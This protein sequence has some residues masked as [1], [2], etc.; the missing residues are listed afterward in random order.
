MGYRYIRGAVLGADPDRPVV[1]ERMRL[2]GDPGSRAPHMWLCGPGDPEPKSTV[3]LY[4]RSF[5][6]LCSEGTPWRAAGRSVAEQL[7][8]PL[9][10]YAIGTGP[11]A[12]L[13]P[14]NGGDWTEVHGTTPQG[15]ILVR[16]DGFVAWR[17]AQAV[18]DPAA[19]LHEVLTTLL[20]RS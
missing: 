3:D 8:L 17:S 13:I 2:C 12:D 6:L 20:D 11:E 14:A 5:V 7:G 10:V 4:E 18:A 9:D 19:V 15:A 1:P 16:P